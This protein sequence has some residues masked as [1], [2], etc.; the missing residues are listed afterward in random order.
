MVEEVVAWEEELS[1]FAARLGRRFHRVE[2]R[3]RVLG[4]LRGLLS[5]IDRKNGWQ[6]AEWLGDSRPDGVQRLLYAAEGDAEGMRDDTR[7][8][9]VTH[10]GHSEAVLIADETGFLKKGT[11]SV[12]VKRQ[13]SGTAGRVENCQV[14]V[15][16]G[17]ATEAGAALID[18]A[19]YLPN[20]WA[21]DAPRREKAGV[22]ESV[23][24]ATKPQ[25]AQEML[26]RAF[27]AGVPCGWVTAD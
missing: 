11:G 1:R 23:S 7:D 14:G 15:F 20:E 3:R 25:L 21:A 16:L 22:P 18:R 12:G 10:L 2:P 8:Y 9:A 6:L 17:Y 26:R 24:F 19:L 4:Y 27:E 5:P 13:Y